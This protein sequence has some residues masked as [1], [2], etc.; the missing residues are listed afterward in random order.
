MVA[1]MALLPLPRAMGV[2]GTYEDIPLGALP[3]DVVKSLVQ[4]NLSPQGRFVILIANGTVRVFDTPQN[5]AQARKAMS[6][7]QNAPA[8]VGF[9]FIIKTGMHK[10]TKVTSSGP[11][12]GFPV[13]QTYSPP[14]IYPSGHGYVVIPS[15]PTSFTTETFGPTTTITQT[16]IEGGEA[17]RYGGTTVFPKPAAVT[18]CAKAPDPAALRDWAVK[19]GAAPES[20]PAW[21]A[22]RTEI[23]VT[24]EHADFG[25]IMTLQPQVVV[26]SADGKSR[27]VPLRVCTASVT[28]KQGTPV[29][30]DGFPGADPDFYRLFLG[31]QESTADTISSVTI[32]A[33]YDYSAVPAPAQTPQPAAK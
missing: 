15:T 20:E 27:V 3:A 14:Q 28:V 17:H 26:T 8:L 19:N 23:L 25:M 31:A 2:S 21:T 4:K 12:E 22:A 10:V 13:P 16:S 33:A 32:G 6:D 7:M 11:V 24:P 1:V 5:I 9:E 18:I 30:L 29:V